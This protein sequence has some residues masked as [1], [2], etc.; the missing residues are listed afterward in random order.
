MHPSIIKQLE[1]AMLKSTLVKDC[2]GLAL[3]ET[4]K[5]KKR[6]QVMQRCYLSNL[7][8]VR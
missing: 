7:H 6:K 5:S 3:L 4:N 2:E 1:K 8:A